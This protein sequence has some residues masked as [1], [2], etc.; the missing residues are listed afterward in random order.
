MNISLVIPCYNEEKNVELFFEE[1]IKVLDKK[2]DVQYVFVNDGSKDNTFLE[3]K[4]VIEK[5]KKLNIMGINFSRNFGKEAAMLAGIKEATGDYIA[6]IDADLQQNPKYINEM[7]KILKDNPEYDCVACYQ[8]KRIENKFVSLLKNAFYKVINMMSEVPFRENASDFRMF[9]RNMA[10]AILEM[11][12]YYRFSKGIFSYIGFNT[13]YIPYEVEERKFGKS[14]WSIWGLFK[15]AFNGII[16]FSTVP[17]KLATCIGSISFILSIIYFL[18]TLFQ[19]IFIGIDISGYASIVCLI[20]LFGGLQ[21]IFLGIIGEYLGR[22]YIE[23][24]KRPKY[25]IKEKL[26]KGTDKK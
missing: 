22:N 19:K 21:M 5:N 4:K 3:I 9:N 15:Y 7:T 12:E 14:S 20:L 10:I 26:G 23:T 16:C 25:I 8:E 1:C 6:I 11:E 2:L 18:I 17:L 24:K 13:K